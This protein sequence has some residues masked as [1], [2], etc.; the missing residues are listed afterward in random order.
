MCNAASTWK[1]NLQARDAAWHFS[2]VLADADEALDYGAHCCRGAASQMWCV[3]VTPHTKGYD[4]DLIQNGTHDEDKEQHPILGTT[5]RVRIKSTGTRGVEGTRRNST[6]KAG[7]V[8]PPV[9]SAPKASVSAALASSASSSGKGFDTRISW[10]RCCSS[11][12]F[13]FL[14]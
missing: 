8:P 11:S 5:H 3:C 10:G 4:G 13:G 9:K 7:P 6:A 2:D 12:R 14:E 1:T